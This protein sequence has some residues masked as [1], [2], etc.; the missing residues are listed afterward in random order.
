MEKSK[1]SSTFTF[2]KRDFLHAKLDEVLKIW[3]RG[4]GKACFMLSLEDGTPN[5][6]HWIQLSLEDDSPASGLPQSQNPTKPL[7]RKRGPAKQAKN[8]QRAAAYQAA[9]AASA[10]Q[11]AAVS[12]ASSSIS[13]LAVSATP[14]AKS[15]VAVPAVSE[16]PSRNKFPGVGRPVGTASGPTLPLPLSN[17]V[18]LTLENTAPAITVSSSSLPSVPS[19][20]VSST[21]N[22]QGLIMAATSQPALSMTPPVRCRDE[23]ASDSDE[24]HDE[25]FDYYK[26]S[27]LLLH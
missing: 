17:S 14:S 6:Q 7:P 10:N 25:I 21:V 8:R 27:H 24:E 4:S 9:R 1:V 26:K 3:L 2:P 12:V 20:V 13:R 16:S 11:T 22:T 19:T 23:I 5:F 15:V 18:S